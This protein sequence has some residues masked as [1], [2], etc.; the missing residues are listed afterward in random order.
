MPVRQFNR[1][2]IWLL[3][4]SLDDLIQDDHP[5]RFI[6]SVVDSLDDSTW[7]K[8]GIVIEGDPLGSPSY[9]PRAML[10]VWLY[11]FMTGT[12]SSRKLE[13]ACRDQVSYMWLTGWQQPDY[14]SLWRFYH[15][16]RQEMRHLFKMTVHTAL[17]IN[18]IDLAIQAV[19]GT[20]VAANANKD[21][22]YDEE[23]LE[24]LISRLDATIEDLEKQ[25]E[26]GIDT[27]P[28]HLP[29]KLSK[30]VT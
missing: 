26:S 6:A 16:H 7:R 29:E 15:A 21:R 10:G 25:N 22:T 18:L 28:V 24:R 27:A 1:Q 8:L 14:V 5:V 2:Q 23:G 20:K 30:R 17:K 12:R 11:G 19:D 13:T 3:P 4:P 9:N